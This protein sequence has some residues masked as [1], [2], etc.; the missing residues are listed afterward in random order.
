[1]A[2][3]PAWRTMVGYQ[4]MF[5][6]R[7]ER[8]HGTRGAE[9]H[10]RLKWQDKAIGLIAQDQDR[11]GN[12]GDPVCAVGRARLLVAISQECC[13]VTGV[14]TPPSQRILIGRISAALPALSAPR[15]AS[16]RAL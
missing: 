15:E 8:S 5:D 11:T 14:S 12:A 10:V 13:A 3:F 7:D 9:Q 4:H 16:A 2:A 1:L 6:A